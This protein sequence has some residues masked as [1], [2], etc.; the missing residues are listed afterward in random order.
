[1]AKPPRTIYEQYTAPRQVSR[2]RFAWWAYAL[3]AVPATLAVAVV[4]YLG[5]IALASKDALD[6]IAQPAIMPTLEA[7]DKPEEPEVENI[8]GQ[9]T[10]LPA[11]AGIVPTTVAN[12]GLPEWRGTERLN[13]LLLGV[14]KRDMDETPRSDTMILVSIDPVSKRIGMLSMP[15]DLYVRIPGHGLDK[16]NAAYPIGE[17]RAA[18]GGAGLAMATVTAN[19]GV[20]IHYYA[21]VDFRGFTRMIDAVGGVTVE[22]PYALKDDAYPADEGSNYTRFF[23]PA[24]LQRMDGLTALRYA[25]SRNFDSD[26][27]RTRRQQQILQAIR[28]QGMNIDNVIFRIP[29]FISLLPSIVKTNI[30]QSDMLSLARLGME[31]NRENIKSHGIT[32]DMVDVHDTSEIFYLQ[33]D[34][35][36]INAALRDMGLGRGGVA[37]TTTPNRTAVPVASPVRSAT[38]T[39]TSV[40][41]TAVRTATAVSKPTERPATVPP[42]QLRLIVRNGTRVAGLAARAADQLRNR[43]HTIIDVAQDPEAG[44][45]PR[46]LI[47]NYGASQAR[48]QAIA[49]SLGLPAS[50]VQLGPPPAPPGVDLVIILGDDAPHP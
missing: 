20:P 39:A 17:Q 45:R 25:R 18:G 48:A 3:L 10:P 14:D 19:F 35:P 43:G 46:S 32:V 27:G 12:G 28:D 9:P 49:Q 21:S 42:E 23:V 5:V 38:A 34:W 29:E 44:R 50:A 24:G 22:V 30:R 26:F 8:P 47:Y 7:I 37:A 16:I 4:V 15:R 11:Q 2:R 40:P 33:P 13:V 36:K 31:I 6:K 41:A 1:M